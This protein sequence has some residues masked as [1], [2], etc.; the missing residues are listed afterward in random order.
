MTADN[1]PADAAR[2]RV[3]TLADIN[4][5]LRRG[6]S[7]EWKTR[8]RHVEVHPLA[9]GGWVVIMG[10]SDYGDPQGG[11]FDY[12]AYRPDQFIRIAATLNM[13]TNGGKFAVTENAPLRDDKPSEGDYYAW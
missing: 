9:I 6:A 13:L 3:S 4:A 1:T 2:P 8:D 11:D 7:L 12:T 10:S 5:A